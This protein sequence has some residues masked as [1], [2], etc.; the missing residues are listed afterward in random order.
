MRLRLVRPMKREG[1]ANSYFEKRIPSDLAPQM[2]G[3]KYVVPLT[4]DPRDAVEVRLGM[5]PRSIRFSLRTASPSESRKRQ[6][7]AIEFF[8]S[9]FAELR[10]HRPIVLSVR[11]G[12]ALSG[13]LY[14]SW[15]EGPDR[16]KKTISVSIVA[17]G[18]SQVSR[19]DDQDAE[20]REGAAAS[21]RR[22]IEAGET[23][24]LD[25]ELYKLVTGILRREGYPHVS[26]ETLNMLVQMFRRALVEGVE[27]GAKKAAWDF[28]DDPSASRYPAWEAP[29][30]EVPVSR[31]EPLSGVSLMGLVEGWWKEALAAGKSDSTYESYSNTFRLFSTFLGHDDA[32]R[33]TPHDVVAFKD[34]RLSS[35]NPKTKRSVS[36]KTVK[37][38]DLTALKSVFDWA[39]S[40]LKVPSNPATG[41][42]VKL[43]KK[44]KVRE[45]DFTNTEASSLLKAASSALDNKT[46][47]HQTDLAKRWVPWLCA[48]SGSRVGEMV[49]LRKEDIRREGEEWIMSVTPEAGT[50]K[51]KEQRDIPLHP[52]LIEM[53][54]AEFVERSKAGY[55][56]MTI[57]PGKTFRGTWQSK[58]NRLAEFAREIVKDP[59]VAPNHGWRHTFKTKGFEAG[60]QEKV[61]DAI[62]GH[63]PASVGRAYGSVSLQTRIDALNAFPRYV[64]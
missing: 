46:R 63:A 40:N 36:A 38:S 7:A 18:D 48:Y 42:T 43:G 2:S 19:E 52:H 62:C 39:V 35:V 24:T 15:A 14:R 4:D 5:S 32:L 17:V 16:T 20:H 49:Q 31:R 64:L 59:N 21:L 11:E 45:R 28:S 22:R 58:K 13:V 29:K 1:S 30:R 61:L 41:V 9:R 10:D 27:S 23:E 6:A 51:G 34:H 54:F 44:M 55:L 26:P 25:A 60:I 53:G 57:K 33:V 56:F 47:P 50:V 12:V 8:E 3:I 37:G